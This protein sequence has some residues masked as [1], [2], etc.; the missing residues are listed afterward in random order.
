VRESEIERERGR[1]RWRVWRETPRENIPAL[2]SVQPQSRSPGVSPGQLQ[3]PY[4][5]IICDKLYQVSRVDET[6]RE[7][8]DGCCRIRDHFMLY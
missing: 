2:L 5:L 1:E 3:R 6:Q 4:P 7:C 8:I